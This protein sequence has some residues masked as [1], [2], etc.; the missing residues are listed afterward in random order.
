MRYVLSEDFN[1]VISSVR[2]PASWTI[3]QF[4]G[5]DFDGERLELTADALSLDGRIDNRVSSIAI[6][7]PASRNAVPAAPEQQEVRV[8]TTVVYALA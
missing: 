3:T 5:R 6:S 7:A 8:T 4:D 2:V 1:D